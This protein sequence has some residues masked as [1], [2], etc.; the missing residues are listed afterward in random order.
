ML[1]LVN[2]KSFQ[3]MDGKSLTRQGNLVNHSNGYRL[4]C[5]FLYHYHP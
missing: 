3:D 1:G 4:L 2:E 5:L